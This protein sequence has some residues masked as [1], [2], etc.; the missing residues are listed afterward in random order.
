MT[1][2]W[3]VA[4]TI[5]NVRSAAFRGVVAGVEA[6][7]NNAVAKILS[8]DK[9]GII[10]R[11]RGV[12]HQA[13]A[14]GEAPASDTGRLAQS[15]RTELDPQGISGQVIFSTA[16]AAAMEFGP[17]DGSIAARP[18]ARPALAEEREGFAEGVSAEVRAA[19]T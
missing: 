13:S 3:D 16:Y 18:Y 6:I 2:T 15:A 4:G 10:Y 5:D 19:L 7:K 11:R 12:D 14:P 17:E 8:G 9:S 1:V